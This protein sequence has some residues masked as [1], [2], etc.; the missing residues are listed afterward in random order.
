M[1]LSTAKEGSSS[2]QCITTLNVVNKAIDK[3]VL[4]ILLM[5]RIMLA[6]SRKDIG[7]FMGLDQKRNGT[8][9]TDT[10][11]MENGTK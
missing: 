3:I 4:R 2:C 10:N 1:N 5:L 9:L 6:N 7:R 8:E 11:P